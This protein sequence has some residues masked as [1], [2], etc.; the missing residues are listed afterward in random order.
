M[1]I[2]INLNLGDKEVS[3][4]NKNLFQQTKWYKFTI[5]NNPLNILN[6][7]CKKKSL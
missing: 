6:M 5:A 2:A 1:S 3:L 4:I 7:V